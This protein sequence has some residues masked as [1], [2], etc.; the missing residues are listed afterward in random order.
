ML[1]HR[2]PLVG[3]ANANRKIFV[4]TPARV[5]IRQHVWP[6]VDEAVNKIVHKAAEGAH[7]IKHI[8]QE[9]VQKHLGLLNAAVAYKKDKLHS[10]LL[11]AADLKQIAATKLKNLAAAKLTHLIAAK[12]NFKNNI[13][14][15]PL[16]KKVPPPFV[17]NQRP[18]I[19]KTI[20]GDYIHTYDNA[21][22]NYAINKD[23]NHY[24]ALGVT[25]FEH[26]QDTVLRELE[27]KE[28]RKVEA[29]L[30]TL[31]EDE[32]PVAPEIRIESKFKIPAEPIRDLLH[33]IED[34]NLPATFEHHH[35]LPIDNGWTPLKSHGHPN[36]PAEE[37]NIPITFSDHYHQDPKPPRPAYKPVYEPISEVHA[38]PSSAFLS[39]FFDNH[40]KFEESARKPVTISPPFAHH[41]RSSSRFE[42]T[43]IT[44][45][46]N[47]PSATQFP[48][49]R[50]HI[51]MMAGGPSINGEST[52]YK[53][54]PPSKIKPKLKQLKT[55]TTPKSTTTT[56]TTSKFTTRPWEPVD[57]EK[58][59]PKIVPKIIGNN[60][61]FAPKTTTQLA[62]ATPQ[63]QASNI[64]TI[65]YGNVHSVQK[66]AEAFPT[67]NQFAK[68]EG[69]QSKIEPVAVKFDTIKSTAFPTA[70]SV[71]ASEKKFRPIMPHSD[72]TYMATRQPTAKTSRGAIK[73]LGSLGKNK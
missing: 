3:V 13:H 5:Q 36:L 35:H 72:K 27:E 16:P 23:R 60:S 10:A 43:T 1:H 6:I 42:T 71:R 7:V 57:F 41:T 69:A 48:P 14:L 15:P 9:G 62:T 54:R 44:N 53:I 8:F 49:L 17:L 28:E 70:T 19:T 56:I 38:T 52:R 20:S 45:D 47:K 21:V 67:T 25:S 58:T 59:T 24:A 32:F 22:P 55:K 30:H 34:Q 26:F 11:E 2:R 68:F 51:H 64:I 73:F 33:P 46:A 61:Y 37:N 63:A 39:P 50:E 12:E 18:L 40:L 31:Y 65:N 29:T 66:K 4:N